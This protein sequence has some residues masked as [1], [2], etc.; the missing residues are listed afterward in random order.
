MLAPPLLSLLSL[1]ILNCSTCFTIKIYQPTY[2]EIQS[3]TQPVTQ[4]FQEHKI[5]CNLPDSSCSSIF[6]CFKSLSR[7][8]QNDRISASQC[9]W[10]FSLFPWLWHK[11]HHRPLKETWQPAGWLSCSCLWDWTCQFRNFTSDSQFYWVEVYNSHDE[12]VLQANIQFFVVP[13]SAVPTQHKT[14]H[15]VKVPVI[16]MVQSSLLLF[17]Y[18]NLFRQNANQ[19]SQVWHIPFWRLNWS[20]A[21]SLRT[22]KMQLLVWPLAA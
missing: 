9:L 2:E 19:F 6:L 20:L 3:Q 7:P 21:S 11:G 17:G 22:F 1:V 16:L 13:D 10:T 5:M 18:F 8:S 15:P 12:F 14:N 4:L